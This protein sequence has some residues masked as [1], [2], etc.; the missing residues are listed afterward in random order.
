MALACM[1]TAFIGFAPTYWVPLAHRSFSA[2]PVIHIHGLL[3]FAWTLYY[4]FQS[5]LVSSGQTTRHR[6]WGILGVSFATAM[7]IFGVL[8]AINLMKQAAALGMTNEGVAF[9]IMPLSGIAFFAVVFT[10]AILARKRSEIHK[11]LML[12]AGISIL[13]AAVARWFLTFL[14]PPGAVGPPPVQ[15][16]I[17]PALCAYLLLVVAIVRDWR[18]EGRPHPVYL[19]RADAGRDQVPELAG[20]HVSGLARLRRRP[21]GVGA[22]AHDPEKCEAVFRKDH[23]PN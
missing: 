12:L 8:A 4:V 21:A 5:W 18:S 9:A 17:V 6:E 16:T 22:V 3:F 2:S 13:D 15:V 14:A 1:A 19:W 10:L 7:T 23:A 20:E 11:R